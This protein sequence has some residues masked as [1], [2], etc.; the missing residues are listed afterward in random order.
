MCNYNTIIKL[1]EFH[2]SLT[3]LKIKF[4]STIIIIVILFNVYFIIALVV[5]TKGV[6]SVQTIPSCM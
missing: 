6:A 5:Q 1:N 3:F 2:I 4:Q